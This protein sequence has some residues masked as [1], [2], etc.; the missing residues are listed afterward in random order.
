[1]TVDSQRHQAY[2]GTSRDM[3]EDSNDQPD[4]Q[5]EH[6]ERSRARRA[7]LGLYGAVLATE[8]SRS[9]NVSFL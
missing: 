3:V 7:E 1:M 6:P 4:C 5:R 9:G 8:D 2:S